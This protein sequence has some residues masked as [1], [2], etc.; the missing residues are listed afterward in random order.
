[1]A[2]GQNSLKSELAGIQRVALIVGVL[3][4]AACGYGYTLDHKQFF[5]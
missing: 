1:M 2:N 5:I 4:A 3:A